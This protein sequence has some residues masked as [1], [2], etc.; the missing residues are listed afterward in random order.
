MARHADAPSPRGIYSGI[1]SLT[2]QVK[3]LSDLCKREQASLLAAAQ[4]GYS[5]GL[6]YLIPNQI[7]P[8]GKIVLHGL[9]IG[10]IGIAFQRFPCSLNGNSL[11]NWRRGL[12]FKIGY[13]AFL[14]RALSFPVAPPGCLCNGIQT[15]HLSENCRKV[16]V[17]S[18]LNEGCG[19]YPAREGFLSA[20]S[21]WYPKQPSDEQDTSGLTDGNALPPAAIPRLLGLFF[22]CSRYIAPACEK[23]FVQPRQNGRV[24]RPAGR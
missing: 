13:D 9:G 12:S 19:Y 17:Y 10:W 4:I 22:G 23:S 6:I 11:Q 7:P 18:C 20:F 5:L 1:H 14:G 21:G 15:C 2:D 8:G 24:F 3:V 16:Y